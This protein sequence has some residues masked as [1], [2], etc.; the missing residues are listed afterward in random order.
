M[1]PL[2]ESFLNF[3]FATVLKI[4]DVNLKV[5]HHKVM[6]DFEKGERNAIKKVC[7]SWEV[8]GCGFHHTQAQV[9]NIRKIQSLI[10][11]YRKDIDFYVY[12]RCFQMLMLLPEDDIPDAVELLEDEQ[13]KVCVYLFLVRQQMR[14]YVTKNTR[15]R[16]AQKANSNNG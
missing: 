6:C 1:Q 4:H 5:D 14:K 7:P 13:H 10:T 16:M 9:T 2:K 15:F 8:K 11:Y 12:C 3:I